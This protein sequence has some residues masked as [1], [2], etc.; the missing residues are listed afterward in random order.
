MPRL[1]GG[2]SSLAS[3]PK[4]HIQGPLLRPGLLA[5]RHQQRDRDPEME[6]V[7]AEATHYSKF[8]LAPYGWCAPSNNTETSISLAPA[9]LRL[10][11]RCA[12]RQP[13]F[14]PVV[15]PSPPA[16]A[17]S[18]HA[19][20]HCT[21]GHTPAAACATSAAPAAHA[22]RSS[23]GRASLGATAAAG[24]RAHR[25]AGKPPAATQCLH[26]FPLHS[27][28]A[29]ACTLPVHATPPPVGP[30]LPCPFAP[31]GRLGRCC[32]GPLRKLG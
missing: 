27:L 11:T 22:T 6:A 30:S 5:K 12:V 9:P 14:A 28:S 26:P 13:L 31:S 17:A 10:F 8:A 3:T 19:A 1:Q 7:V 2:L 20:G 29:P 15:T 21:C 16:C 23:T 32:P 24:A 18:R 25:R 4:P